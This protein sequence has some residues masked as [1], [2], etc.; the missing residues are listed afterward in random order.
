MKR[1]GVELA[2]LGRLDVEIWM[3]GLNGDGFDFGFVGSEVERILLELV[4]SDVGGGVE[5]VVPTGDL[6][7]II[8][9][10]CK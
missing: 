1:V 6:I 7:R 4:E 10:H 8:R 3:D 5:V 2:D 9:F